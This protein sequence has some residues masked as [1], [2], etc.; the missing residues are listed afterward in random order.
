MIFDL[1]K[2]ATHQT[3]NLLIGLV[4]P[5]RIA[6]ISSIDLAGRINVASF[7]AHNYVGIDPPLLRHPR[8]LIFCTG[9][10]AA[11]DRDAVTAG[12]SLRNSPKSII[13]RLPRS[14]FYAIPSARRSA[15]RMARRPSES[16]WLK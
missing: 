14:I 9:L 8:H 2:V 4:A 3:Y 6:W 10:P 13:D 11:G 12:D 5:R 7:S 16:P 1:S 15:Q